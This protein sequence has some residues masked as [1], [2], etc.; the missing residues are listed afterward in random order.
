MNLVLNFQSRSYHG[1]EKSYVSYQNQS[2]TLTLQY[3]ILSVQDTYTSQKN[4]IQL[5]NASYITIQA[6]FII[7][8][9]H[10]TMIHQHKAH[11]Y[12]QTTVLLQK[13][14]CTASFSL[15]TMHIMICTII[16]HLNTVKNQVHKN[17]TN[18]DWRKASN[19]I[20]PLCTN[21]SYAC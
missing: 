20:N 1:R 11:V 5:R 7:T 13:S 19:I 18:K 10:E 14:K 2:S 8:N 21:K 3:L 12:I 17:L 9:N 16:I 15:S 4:L 6:T